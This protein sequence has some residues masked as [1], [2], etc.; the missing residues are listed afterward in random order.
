MSSE[1]VLFDFIFYGIF[2]ADIAYYLLWVKQHI[3]KCEHK[4]GLK[5]YSFKF[6]LC[7]NQQN[8]AIIKIWSDLSCN[9]IFLVSIQICT[10]IHFWHI[11]T[12]IAVFFLII[13]KWPFWLDHFSVSLT[14][15]ENNHKSVN[16]GAHGKAT[17]SF[18]IW[19]TIAC[20]SH[21]F[22][23]LKSHMNIRNK[24]SVWTNIILKYFRITVN[25]FLH[26]DVSQMPGS[27]KNTPASV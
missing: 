9:C 20:L 13:R 1:F 2:V 18:R 3:L 17:R 6:A 23:L 26:L 14:Y 27:S 21:F 24:C 12:Y 22:S 25:A 5:N 16:A 10:E 11:H 19:E 7:F 8:F 4:T 15:S